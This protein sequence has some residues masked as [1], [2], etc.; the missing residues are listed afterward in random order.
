MAMCFIAQLISIWSALNQEVHSHIR[1]VRVLCGSSETHVCLTMEYE[2]LPENSAKAKVTSVFMAIWP[3][4]HAFKHQA[5]TAAQRL[6][7]AV[8][9][10]QGRNQCCTTPEELY[11]D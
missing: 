7:P 10:E 11:D 4:P 6:D 3:H 2:R 1:A 9:I 5:S 8:C